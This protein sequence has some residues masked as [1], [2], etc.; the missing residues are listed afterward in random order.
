MPLEYGPDLRKTRQVCR[1]HEGVS[2]VDPAVASAFS[3][4]W[5]LSFGDF[6]VP[7]GQIPAVLNNGLILGKISDGSKTFQFYLKVPPGTLELDFL[8]SDA[9]PS[10]YTFGQWFFHSIECR[11]SGT[12]HNGLNCNGIGSYF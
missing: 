11:R 6:A 1:T 7:G 12:C 8:Q 10:L 5:S 3:S 4:P 9:D 2:R